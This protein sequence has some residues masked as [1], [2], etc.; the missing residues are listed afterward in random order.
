MI[1]FSHSYFSLA[2]VSN[3]NPEAEGGV[4]INMVTV[5]QLVSFWHEK[6]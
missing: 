1:N 5:N 6:L 3:H 4:E 2:N